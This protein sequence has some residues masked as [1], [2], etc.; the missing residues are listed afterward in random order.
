VKIAITDANLLIELTELG[1][2][3]LLLQTG[4][5]IH[6]TIDMIWQLPLTIRERLPVENT[7]LSLFVHTL[8]GEECLAIY[9]EGSYEGMTH[10][11]ICSLF[12]A[13]KIGAHV[14]W[15]NAV[16]KKQAGDLAV[17]CHGMLWIVDIIVDSG[18]LSAERA[19]EIANKWITIHPLSKTSKAI[20]QAFQE[21]VR[22]WRN[23]STRN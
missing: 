6:C 14:P 3:D 2:L 16:A 15:A 22:K 5:E 20:L 11:E 12:L 7:D 9:S 4:A 13:K 21:N 8:Q 23:V 19:L 17:S 18:V 1:L 10:G